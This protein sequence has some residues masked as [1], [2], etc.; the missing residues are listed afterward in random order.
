[1]AEFIKK[2]PKLY[3]AV[4]AKPVIDAESCRKLSG[5]AIGTTALAVLGALLLGVGMCLSMVFGKMV[6]GVVI[7]LVGIVALLM[8]IP[9]V[10]GLQ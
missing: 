8:L 1:M 2:C 5:K 10:K 9:L 4:P 3:P 6:L 7:G